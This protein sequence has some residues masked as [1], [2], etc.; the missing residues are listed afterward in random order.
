MYI[1][2][3]FSLNKVIC[4]QLLVTINSI[5]I[6]SSNSQPIRFNIVIP[7]GE[8][9]LFTQKIKATFSHLN[10]TTFR[11]QEYSPM[12]YLKQYLDAK[13]PEKRLDRKTSRYMQ[14]ARLFL[15]DIFPDLNKVIY[16]DVDLIVR[17]CL[18]KVVE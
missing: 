3:A 14:Y 5:L 7:E 1:D 12:P 17:G 13:F 18:R 10:N 4:E 2:I 8:K 6:N 15:K 11:L 16:L 9:K